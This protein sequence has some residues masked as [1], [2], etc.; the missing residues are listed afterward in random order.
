MRK[1][2][3]NLIFVL[4][5]DKVL[6]RCEAELQLLEMLLEEETNGEEHLYLFNNID[7]YT[8]PE[9]IKVECDEQFPCVN[10]NF[11]IE[12]LGKWL[13]RNIEDGSHRNSADLDEKKE[14]MQQLEGNNN[15][16][17]QGDNDV[18]AKG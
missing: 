6:V 17:Q 16:F 18:F 7:M 2:K 9:E 15:M 1:D 4:E 3:Q 10:T 11:E 5:K 14:E 8:A 12:F 13:A